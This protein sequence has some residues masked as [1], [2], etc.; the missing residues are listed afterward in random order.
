MNGVAKKILMS[1]CNY[2]SFKNVQSNHCKS[3]NVFDGW[4]I[5]VCDTADR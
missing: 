3:T 5:L 4:P 1:Y 2:F